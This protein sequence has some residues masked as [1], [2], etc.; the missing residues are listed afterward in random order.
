MKLYKL[1]TK[2][3]SQYLIVIEDIENFVNNLD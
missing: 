1:A 3:P 2:E